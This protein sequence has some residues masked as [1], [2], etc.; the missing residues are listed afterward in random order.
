MDPAR[1]SSA[2]MKMKMKMK[3]DLQQWLRFRGWELSSGGCVV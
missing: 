3:R 2:W 1:F